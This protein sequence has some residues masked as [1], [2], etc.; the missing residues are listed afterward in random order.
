MHGDL[1]GKV[2]FDDDL[3]QLVIDVST[4]GRPPAFASAIVVEAVAFEGADSHIVEPLLDDP[5]FAQC[6]LR[7]HI[8][9]R[10]TDRVAGFDQLRTN[11]EDPYGD[12]VEL[13]LT[14]ATHG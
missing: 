10:V 1:T 6:L 7:A 4:Y 5:D 8:Y 12:V 11:S 14:L 2:L 3:P 9:R 13:A